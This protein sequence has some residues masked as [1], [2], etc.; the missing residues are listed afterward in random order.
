[1]LT[2]LRPMAEDLLF[3]AL[4]PLLMPQALHVRRN[5]PRFAPPPGPARGAVGDGAVRTLLGVGDS[6]IA[7]VGAGEPGRALVGQTATALQ[8]AAGGRIEWH[9]VGRVGATAAGA[10]ER[11]VPALPPDRADFVVVS[12][13]VNDVTGLT[14]LG[15]WRRD[16]GELL[17]RLREHSPEATIA[18]SGLPPLGSFPLLPRPLSALFGLRA[19]SLD[20]VA[21]EVVSALPQTVHV[22]L[23]FARGAGKFAADGFHPC[24]AGYAEYG[25]V[26]ARAMAG[27]PRQLAR[28][29]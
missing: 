25:E 15:A 17:C 23:V 7:G 10:T 28:A 8:R 18:L 26:V 9:A 22:P 19:R 13:G 1:M 24:E 3:W 5:A 12:V 14:A 20:A 21:R 27:Q 4:L 2:A 11:L 6:I 16:L 29:R